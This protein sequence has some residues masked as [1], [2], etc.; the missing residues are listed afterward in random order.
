MFGQ[1][2]NLDAE[3]HGQVLGGVKLLPVPFIGELSEGCSK[4][5]YGFDHKKQDGTGTIRYRQSALSAIRL[6]F[7]P[8]DNVLAVFSGPNP[9]QDLVAVL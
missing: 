5:V 2:G 8:E 1:F 7:S 6:L 3:G 9:E 4:I